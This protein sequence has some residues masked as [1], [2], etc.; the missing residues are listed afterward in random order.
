MTL[1]RVSPGWMEWVI[2]FR[3][4]INVIKIATH[5]DDFMLFYANPPYVTFLSLPPL[6]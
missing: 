6:F 5:T 1:H 2:M 4:S 3:V